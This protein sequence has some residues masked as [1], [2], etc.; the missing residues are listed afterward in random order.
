[1][2]ATGEHHEHGGADLRVLFVDDEPRV[3]AALQ[4]ML[5]GKRP[6]W[7]LRFAAGGAQALDLLADQPV[8]VVV[9]DLRM[10]GMDGA[11]LLAAVREGYPH[12]VRVVLS[13]HTEREATLRALP[14]AHRFL[15][16]PCD[17]D[18]LA[19]A[20]ARAATVP[21]LLRHPEAR[22]YVGSVASLPSAPT[23]WTAL[24]KRLSDPAVSVNEV[25]GI[26][27]SDVAMSAKL[28]QLVN[29]SF[30]GLAR[31]LT[32]IR[33]AVIYL[34]L[35]MLRSLVLSVEAFRAFAGV[36][37]ASGLSVDRLCAH[38]VT[39]AGL[40]AELVSDPAQRDDAFTAA[41]LADVGQLVLTTCVPTGFGQALARAAQGELALHAAELEL[42]G[43][44]HGDVGAYLLS[45]WGLPTS[46]V[47]AVACHH[48]PVGPPAGDVPVTQAVRL[49]HL[50]VGRQAEQPPGA[51]GKAGQATDELSAWLDA[52]GERLS[53]WLPAAAPG[54]RASTAI[55][56]S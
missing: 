38:G 55:L 50:L 8:D 16:K 56:E 21:R 15:N 22:D 35:P 11:E 41:L 37:R 51:A 54:S 12:V 2:Q 47:D 36:E 45:V 5:Q 34:G 44:H 18:T 6:A 19:E 28:L 46:V 9:S 49:A 27:G 43:V 13:A 33:E 4:R 40:A 30:V 17:A 7:T 3:L 14:V 48:D 23:I 26:V 31:Q 42:F 52:F 29:S 25:A 53:A 10:P 32:S 1:M 20:I 39:C 24:S